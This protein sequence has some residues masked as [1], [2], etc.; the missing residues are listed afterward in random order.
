MFLKLSTL[1]FGLK[2]VF[3]KLVGAPGEGLQLLKLRSIIRSI[4]TAIDF[5]LRVWI[6][7]FDSLELWNFWN[8]HNCWIQSVIKMTF[9][10]YLLDVSSRTRHRHHKVYFIALDWNWIFWWEGEGRECFM[11]LAPIAINFSTKPS[12]HFPILNLYFKISKPNFS[13]IGFYAKT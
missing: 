2:S 8:F 11:L 1:D 12:D 4:V 13:I 3:I 5:G 10:T 6:K 7:F 9:F